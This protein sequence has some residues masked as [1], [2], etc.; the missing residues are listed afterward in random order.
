MSEAGEAAFVPA[1]EATFRATELTRGPWNPEHQ[2]AGPPIALVARAIERTAA[3]LDLTH[4]ARLTAN[5]LRPIPIG[6]LSIDVQTEYAGRNVAHLAA[7]LSAAG[8]QVARFTAVAHREADVEI[9]PD[10]AGHPLP[11]A[12]RTVE[13]SA[14]VRFPFSRKTRGYQDYV[15]ARTAQGVFFRGACAIW[16]RMRHPLVAGEEPSGLQRVAVAAD[17]T[18]GVSSVLEF[19]RYMFVNSDLTINLLRR[20]RGEWI[21][22]DAQT[23]IGPEGSG[24][25]ESRLFDV[26]GLIG[27]ATQSLP[28]RLREQGP[29]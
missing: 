9:P 7:Q 1:G 12:P 10:L 11:Q 6:E 29:P 8:K 4:I 27:R 25:A 22:I 24:L 17:S 20:A 26:D 21:C 14:G 3:A 15:E 5:L 13:D 23:H 16:I 2:H 19:R 28:V 18:N